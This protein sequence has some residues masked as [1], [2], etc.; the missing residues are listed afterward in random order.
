MENIVVRKSVFPRKMPIFSAEIHVSGDIYGISDKNDDINVVQKLTYLI[1]FTCSPSNS[2]KIVETI[3]AIVKEEYF[4]AK[5]LYDDIVKA[6]EVTDSFT[7]IKVDIKENL[8]DSKSMRHSCVNYSNGEL[9]NII[10]TE[11]FIGKDS[12]AGIW[13]L[14]KTGMWRYNNR[15]F[16]IKGN[17]CD[18]ADIEYSFKASQKDIAEAVKIIESNV[19]DKAFDAKC[20]YK[21]YF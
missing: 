6:I 12:D 10:F 13:N 20:L 16:E 4:F 14:S 11:S 3:E 5:M 9:Q 18:E 15:R 2:E 17:A 21:K 19:H 7:S 8:V 1:V